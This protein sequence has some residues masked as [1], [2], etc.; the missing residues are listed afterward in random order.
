MTD[1]RSAAT[2]T[3][4]TGPTASAA[5]AAGS[6]APAA[7]CGSAAPAAAASRRLRGTHDAVKVI[8]TREDYLDAVERHRRRARPRRGRRRA[9]LA[10]TA[11]RSAPT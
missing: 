4:S 1:A 9:R 5:T 3:G 2:P 8:D 6:T 11:T 7:D 10:A